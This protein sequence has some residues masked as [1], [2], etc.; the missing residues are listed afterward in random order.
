VVGFIGHA[1]HRLC[2]CQKPVTQLLGPTTLIGNNARRAGSNSP[3]R[4]H[5]RPE[6]E[7][8]LTRGSA[9]SFFPRFERPSDRG[10]QHAVPPRFQ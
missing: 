1:S 2:A 7:L 4:Q 9:H 3:P 8:G 5:R 6:P 10:A